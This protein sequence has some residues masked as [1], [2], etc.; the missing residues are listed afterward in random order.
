MSHLNTPSWVVTAN[1]N[2]VLL[3]WP[4]T[5]QTPQNQSHDLTLDHLMHTLA[6]SS[7]YFTCIYQFCVHYGVSALGLCSNSLGHNSLICS[8][9]VSPSAC[10]LSHPRPLLHFPHTLKHFNASLSFFSKHIKVL[11]EHLKVLL[12][13]SKRHTSLLSCCCHGKRK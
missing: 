5:N 11:T 4:S 6:V 3:M 10:A 12:S 7:E 13:T 2:L 9:V 1:T 8:N